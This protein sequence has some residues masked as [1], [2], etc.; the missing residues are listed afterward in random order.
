MGL[1]H[2]QLV[3]LPRPAFIHAWLNIP[4]STHEDILDNMKLFLID[5]VCL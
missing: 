3:C 4:R 1:P 2:T 5:E